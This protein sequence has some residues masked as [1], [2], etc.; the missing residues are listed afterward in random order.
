LTY[1]GYLDAI[2]GYNDA[3]W[4]TGSNNVKT[5]IG[6]VFLFGDAVIS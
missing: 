5:T 4:V 2:K 3:N 1:I 6:F